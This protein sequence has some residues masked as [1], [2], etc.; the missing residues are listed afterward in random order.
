[1]QRV[2]IAVYIAVEYIYSSWGICGT[3]SYVID[4]MTAPP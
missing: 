3:E 4:D 1:M 2:Y